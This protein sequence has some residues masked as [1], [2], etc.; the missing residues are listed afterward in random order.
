MDIKFAAQGMTKDVPANG[1]VETSEESYAAA[2]VGEHRQGYTKKDQKD[3]YRMGKRQELMVGSMEH[4]P[5]ASLTVLSET[6]PPS[7]P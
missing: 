2:D 6:F 5:V 3:M 7:L 1:D 4:R